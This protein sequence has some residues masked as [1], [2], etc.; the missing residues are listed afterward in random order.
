MVQYSSCAAI[1]N[2]NSKMQP[3]TDKSLTR[4]Q[5]RT[6]LDR[7]RGSKMVIARELGL[8]STSVSRWLAGTSKS[9]RVEAACRA[10]AL[11]YL[12]AEKLVEQDAA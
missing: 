4:V 11:R 1:T 9:R 6:V 3:Q 5:T 7:Y 12:A 8:S 2:H 10:A